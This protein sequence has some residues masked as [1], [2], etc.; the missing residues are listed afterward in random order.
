MSLLAMVLTCLVF[1]SVVV[2]RKPILPTAS[3]SLA[4]Q[5]SLVAGSTLV[6]PLRK[7]NAVTAKDSR[8]WDEGFGLGWWR[9]RPTT[10]GGGVG[11]SAETRMR[12]G[13]DAGLLRDKNPGRLPYRP[14][15]DG[16]L[17]SG[18]SYAPIELIDAEGSEHVVDNQIAQ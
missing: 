5:M 6:K 14:R 9:Q 4:A 13:V 1:A 16:K 18:S 10:N 7:D 15:G 3:S 17:P 8:V 2:P 12:W 11:S